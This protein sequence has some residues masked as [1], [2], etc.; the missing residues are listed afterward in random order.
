[1][2]NHLYLER[3]AAMKKPVIMSTGMSSL[4]EVRAAVQVL[5]AAGVSELALLHCVSN[6]PA[7]PANVN[8]R[9][10]RT[11][12]EAFDVP[13]GYSDHTL[14]LDVAFASVAMGACVIEKHFTLDTQLPGPDHQASLTPTQLRD[15]VAGIR[16]IESAFGDGV[17]RP[18]TSEEDTQN[19]ARRSLVLSK[20][21][22]AGA[23][24][25]KEHLVAL[26]P[27]GGIPP[28]RV[29][30]VVGKRARLS[31]KGGTMLQWDHLE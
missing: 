28:D 9:A 22:V 15:L 30:D 31:L 19:V 8:L 17:K 26:R 2:T 11:L 16:R 25:Q 29:A 6:Y 10:M 4:E 3:I 1:V 5:T 14:A 13:V 24:I 20:D 27:S 23:T 18:V 21:L 12:A 7:D